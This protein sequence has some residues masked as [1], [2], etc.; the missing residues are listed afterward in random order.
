M[1]SKIAKSFAIWKAFLDIYYKA[2][3]LSVTILGPFWE[4]II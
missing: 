2:V 3:N 4:S 1:P